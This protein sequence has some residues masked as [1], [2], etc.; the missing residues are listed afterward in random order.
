MKPFEGMLH[1]WQVVGTLGRG[2][3]STV[4]SVV[5]AER[6]GSPVFA[7]KQAI[8]VDRAGL[9]DEVERLERY[10]A[11]ERALFGERAVSRFP[12]VVDRDAAG[13]F[14]VM[15]R[16]EGISL[17]ELINRGPRLSEP[18]R[19]RLAAD[20]AEALAVVED[21]G[22]AAPDLKADA[23]YWRPAVERATLVDWNVMGRADAETCRHHARRVATML[24]ALFAGGAVEEP[25]RSEAP[26]RWGRYPR[27]VGAVLARLHHAPLGA[28]AAAAMLH[29]LADTLALSTEARFERARDALA[30]TMSAGSAEAVSGCADEA[31]G[32]IEVASGDERREMALLAAEL[33]SQARAAAAEP[34]QVVRVWS[35]AP[36]D[37]AV[38][39]DR[40]LLRWARLL[41]GGQEA[42]AREAA[43]HFAHQRWDAAVTLLVG[44][45]EGAGR[46]S[47]TSL[48]VEAVVL[49]AAR[50][51]WRALDADD[52]P[53]ADAAFARCRAALDLM[54]PR[55]A[56]LAALPL[57]LPTPPRRDDDS[58]PVATDRLR[59][60]QRRL[61]EHARARI[62][63]LRGGDEV[64]HR[65]F[66]EVVETWQALR[67][68]DP[69]DLWQMAASLVP[70][71]RAS[72][73]A[74]GCLPP[75]TLALYAPAVAEAVRRALA[76]T[77][78][79]RLP[80]RLTEMLSEIR[81]DLHAIRVALT[82]RELDG[83]LEVLVAQAVHEALGA[84]DGS[85]K[86]IEDTRAVLDGW[87]SADDD[88]I[89]AAHA[90]RRAVDAVGPIALLMAA[91]D[92][93][94]E[95]LAARYDADRGA[96]S[97]VRE[98]QA[99]LHLPDR[100]RRLGGRVVAAVVLAALV[101]GAVAVFFAGGDK[102][103]EQPV[104]S[105]V[106]LRIGG[107]ASPE[108]SRPAA[109]AAADAGVG[110]GA[111]GGQPDGRAGLPD[112]HAEL[113]DGNAGWLNGNAEWQRAF[114]GVMWLWRSK[115]L[116]SQPSQPS[117]PPR[118]SRP[119]QPSQPPQPSKASRESSP[120]ESARPSKPR[121]PTPTS[122]P[123][124][125]SPKTP[126]AGKR[127]MTPAS[128]ASDASK[129]PKASTTPTTPKPSR[130]SRPSAAADARPTSPQ[131]SSPPTVEDP[132]PKPSEPT[133]PGEAPNPTPK[134][135]PAAEPTGRRR[136]PPHLD[137]GVP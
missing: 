7:L 17:V 27:R 31:L 68:A 60:E 122:A 110:Q 94:A 102:P 65:A 133:S 34:G 58:G 75:S 30:R 114:A 106:L 59:E 95:P 76:A 47:I 107:P 129:S 55:G 119:S 74:G 121:H 63:A 25:G 117:Q 77:L 43:D 116:P 85:L 100:R 127:P 12:R 130:P 112:G 97:A 98:A 22:E 123:P 86:F 9:I 92:A 32:W 54:T 36:I 93:L 48:Y 19:A 135:S 134:A 126:P 26:P 46:E 87:R 71:L 29:A 111:D 108:G 96:R 67:Q 51:G 28:R 37:D 80:E 88:P 101:G 78:D 16:V 38:I 61:V 90:L 128:E 83:D 115:P 99:L 33:S 13:R 4:Y 89:E 49:D 81:S 42:I 45:A 66:V 64:A 23:I 10:A 41:G 1:R 131:P 20:V 69:S 132:D 84:I 62:G 70:A 56:L 3:T 91:R 73:R 6:D 72:A 136:L 57:L 5:D 52:R 105:A 2:A 118:P 109:G 11:R 24:D 120:A 137:L 124:Q 125:T 79:P 21:A 113:P 8:E 103:P 82:A 39:A 18:Q 35:G 40:R 44:R 104:E 50:A 53:A 14:F 15:E